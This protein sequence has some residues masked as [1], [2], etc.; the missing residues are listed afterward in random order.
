MRNSKNRKI[1]TL[2]CIVTIKKFMTEPTITE[3]IDEIVHWDVS[4]TP[5][6]SMVNDFLK[7]S[8][9]NIEYISE[10]QKTSDL[11]QK[12]EVAS[13][14][15]NLK[16]INAKNLSIGIVDW[17][18]NLYRNDQSGVI[19]IVA[20]LIVIGLDLW[21]IAPLQ[22]SFPGLKEFLIAPAVLGGIACFLGIL[23]SILIIPDLL[24][25]KSWKR[26]HS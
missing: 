17:H 22:S 23:G 26:Q 13:K 1:R 24:R 21:F 6:P 5:I 11:K 19:L 10:I 4:K 7:E 14:I 20:G 8:N 3:V 9:I 18:Y 25:M 2:I 12:L 15:Y 16:T